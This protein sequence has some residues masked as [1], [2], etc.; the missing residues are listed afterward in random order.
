VAPVT[1]LRQHRVVTASREAT[2]EAL[3]WWGI[4]GNVELTVPDRGSNNQTV[5]VTQ[6][7]QGWVLRI[8]QNLS[9]GQVRA[10]HRLLARLRRASADSAPS[11]GIG[12]AGSA[13]WL[14]FAVPEPVPTIAGETVL[15]TAAGPATLTRRIEGIRPDLSREAALERVG[16]SLGQLTLALRDVPFGDAPQDWRAGPLATLPEGAGV[17]DV[18]AELTR[19]G[20]SAGPIGLLRAQAARAAAWYESARGQLA[21]QVVHGD[22]GASNLLVDQS[23]GQVTGV[24]DFEIAGADFRIQDLVAA[25]LLSG[26]LEGR[27]LQAR[28]AALGRGAAS[29][30]AFAEA[31]TDAVPEL[32]V[33]RSV[34]S[35]L[36]RAGRW[37][38]GL[39]TLD[40]VVDR[41]DELAATVG[42]VSRFG[43]EL[44]ELLAPGPALR[45]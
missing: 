21:V 25:L 12:P 36:W 26:A 37:R 44:R 2:A 42:F 17:E 4:R 13:P 16:I 27:H 5:L 32:L 33:C 8:S 6:G 3:A 31:E 10:E 35:V 22:L 38:R 23:S 20:V 19:A 15:D 29:V 45:G 11:Q 14:P 9:A 18:A 24:L 28:A 1:P 40:D 41:L 34:G 39:S 43:P 7:D 30:S